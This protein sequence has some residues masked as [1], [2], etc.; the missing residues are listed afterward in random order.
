M[1][2]KNLSFTYLILNAMWIRARCN[3][4]VGQFGLCL[5]TKTELLDG[6]PVL[7]YKATDP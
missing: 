6:F 4:G 3:T 5:F 7:G 1:K 2:S